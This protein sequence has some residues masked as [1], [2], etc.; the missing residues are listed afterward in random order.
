M[1]DRKDYLELLAQLN[2]PV[3]FIAGKK[4]SR[5]PLEK[6]NQQIKLPKVCETLILDNVGHMGFIEAKEITYNA[7]KGFTWKYSD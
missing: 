1:R 7:I 5:I 3:L 2:I 6:I 4:D